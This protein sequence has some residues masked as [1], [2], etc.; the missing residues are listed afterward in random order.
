MAIP[1]PK[2]NDEIGLL[3]TIHVRKQLSKQEQKPL[4][5]G[6]LSFAHSD[7]AGYSVFE[8]AFT[9]GHGAGTAA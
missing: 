6:R 1:V 4:T 2:N 9:L 5:Y 7:W 3:R 8:E